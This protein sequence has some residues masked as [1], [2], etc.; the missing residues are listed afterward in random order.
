MDQVRF[1]IAKELESAMNNIMSQIESNRLFNEEKTSCPRRDPKVENNYVFLD[2][3]TKL[4]ILS[5]NS[6]MIERSSHNTLEIEYF[7]DGKLHNDNKPAYLLYVNKKLKCEEYYKNGK[8]HNLNG[9]ASIEYYSN[10]HFEYKAYYQDGK[11]H[12]DNGFAKI[13][14]YYN[15]SVKYASCYFNGK[16]HR[17]NGP[18]R[19]EYNKDGKVV[20]SSY[21]INDK[22]ITQF[23]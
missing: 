3:N 17:D 5:P 12:N 19:I 8:L 15:G 20:Y 7:K 18:A 1:I 21:Y 11:L 10:G 4:T 16:R 14:Y 6:Y 23:N 2:K 9:A 13:E 22:K